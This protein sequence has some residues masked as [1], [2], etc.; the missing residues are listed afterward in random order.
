MTT[1]ITSFSAQGRV[2]VTVLQPHGDVDA[3]NFLDLIAATQ[4]AYAAGERNMLLDLGHVPYLSSSGLVALHSM[5]ALMRGDTPPD[6]ESGWE[7]LRAI[8][9]DRE[10]GM[11][12]HFKLLNV[13]PRVDRVL[14]TVGFKRFL[15]VHTDLDAAINSF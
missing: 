4:K 8:G 6:P 11:Q 10:L 9:R 12:S 7:A 14:E 5:A 15:E 13:Q 2:P 1:A 3:S